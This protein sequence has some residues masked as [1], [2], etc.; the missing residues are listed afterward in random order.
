[1]V[2]GGD[3]VVLRYGENYPRRQR[4]GHRLAGGTGQIVW[5]WAVLMGDIMCARR[6][7]VFHGAQGVAMSSQRLMRGVGI[8]LANL[9]VPRGFAM[10][11][12]RLLVMHDRGRMVH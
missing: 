1:M 6:L 7:A 12:R 8:V 11:P 5:Q 2:V 3:G 9:V 4:R 10:E